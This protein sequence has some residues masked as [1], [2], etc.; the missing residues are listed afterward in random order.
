LKEIEDDA[1]DTI[2]VDLIGSYTVTDKH[3]NEFTLQAHTMCDPATDWFEIVEIRDQSS[4]D[5][6]KIQDQI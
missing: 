2:C 6:A 5:A 4:E 3:D 1:W